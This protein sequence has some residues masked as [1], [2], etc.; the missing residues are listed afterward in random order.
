MYKPIFN[1]VTIRFAPR[2][3]CCNTQAIDFFVLNFMNASCIVFPGI[4]IFTGL[5]MVFFGFSK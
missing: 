5:L 4:H 3:D 2:L 1:V